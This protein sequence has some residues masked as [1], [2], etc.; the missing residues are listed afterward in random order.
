MGLRSQSG[1]DRS[2]SNYLILSFFFLT[3]LTGLAY[4]LAWIRLLILAFGSTQFAVTTVLVTFMSGIALGSLIFG[5]IVDRFKAP[6]KLYGIIE[7][8]LGIYCI[9]SPLV[10]Y[11]VKQIYLSFASFE[12]QGAHI[13]SFEASQFILSFLALIIPTTLMGGTLPVLVKYLTSSSGKVGYHTA[14][15]YSI[16]TLG[17]VTGCL[18]TGFFSMYMLGVKATVYSAGLI[19]IIIGVIV[20]YRY[21]KTVVKAEETVGAQQAEAVIG[22]KNLK[23]LVIGSFALSG[24]A[25]LTYEVLWTRVFSLVLG[26]SIYAF[27]IMLAT[28]L[29]GIGIGSII[30]APYIDKRKNY[31]TWFA[32]LEAIIGL[33]SLLS[34]FIY[35]ELPFIFFNIK[36]AFAT[37]FWA[38]LFLQFLLCAAIMIIPTLCM[39]AI[40]PLV[41]KICTRDLKGVGKSIGDIYFFNTAG[42]I[43]GAFVGGFFLIPVIGVQNGVVITAGLNILI[44]IVLLIKS[45]VKFIAKAVAGSLVVMVFSISVLILPEW[46]KM[47]MTL[48][49]YSNQM[50]EKVLTRMKQGEQTERLLYYKE[51]INAIVTVREGGKAFNTVSYQANGKEEAR[52]VD[53]RPGEAWSILGHVPM[54]LHSGTPKDALLVGLGSGITL[55]AMQYYP[56]ER[57]DVVELEPAVVESAR[58]FSLANNNAVDDPRVK[59]HVTD[60]RSFLSVAEKKYD[61]IVSGVSDPWIT[62]VSNLFTQEYFHALKKRLNDDGVV[63]LWFQNYRITPNEFRIGINTFASVFPYVSIWFHY[64]DTLDLVVIGSTKPHG[65]DLQRLNNRFS[66]E[67]IR[68]GLDRINIKNPYDVLDLYL[69][70]NRDLRSYLGETALNTDEKP[71]LEFTLPKL[72]YLDPSLGIKTVEELIEATNDVIPPVMVTDAGREA[73]Y[74]SL[75]KTYYRSNFRLRQAV[76][77]FQKAVEVNPRNSE[78]VMYLNNLNRE[79]NGEFDIP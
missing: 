34:I 10:F 29:A 12:P 62:G 24:F 38:F 51:G 2:G 42:S 41:G 43:F 63:G 52:S 69:I 65:F 20:Y 47:L 3:G 58:F 33:V 59:M 56:V 35:R 49:L 13:A 28:F 19:D 21:G 44:F 66:D 6:L 71:I 18:L 5:R 55:G 76:V 15:P 4:E 40:F 16:N 70:G 31:I 37:Q 72:Q 36:E 50:H 30:F 27:T 8:L 14:V 9:I 46:E 61:V 68:E 57:F 32:A 1:F 48:G 25:S 23:Y 17:A 79:M 73:F 77:A 74:V 64:T 75:G 54:L 67:K 7:V 60:G 22:N 11:T 26:S 53:G 39:G 45:E 78:A